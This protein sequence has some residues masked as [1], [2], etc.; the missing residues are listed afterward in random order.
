MR[1]LASAEFDQK[2][3]VF[4]KDESQDLH[5]PVIER[6]NPERGEISEYN[7][8]SISVQSSSYHC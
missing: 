5:V 4:C 2:C 6:L 7:M 1:L 3:D 8:P